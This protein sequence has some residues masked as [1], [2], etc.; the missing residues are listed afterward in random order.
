MGKGRLPGALMAKVMA[1]VV[2]QGVALV[3]LLAILPGIVPARA[4]TAFDRPGGDY[5]NTP[6]NEAHDAQ[7][8][9]ETVL[10]LHAPKLPVFL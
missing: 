8:H 4:Q 7:A 1:R 10:L 5:L 9:A 2:A 6:P 3:M